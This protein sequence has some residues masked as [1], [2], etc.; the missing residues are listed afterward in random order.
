MIT[1]GKIVTPLAPLTASGNVLGKFSETDAHCSRT[2]RPKADLASDPFQVSVT[3]AM[4]FA[5]LG[6]D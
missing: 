2:R 1:N 5:R 4:E 6:G 3:K